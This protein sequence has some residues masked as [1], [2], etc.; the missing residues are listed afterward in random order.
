MITKKTGICSLEL[1]T[2]MYHDENRQHPIFKYVAGEGLVVV[3]YI[4]WDE[5]IKQTKRKKE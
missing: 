2:T 4:P 1:G 3:G 5:Y